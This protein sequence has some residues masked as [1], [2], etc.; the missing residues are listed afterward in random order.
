[1]AVHNRKTLRSRPHLPWRNCRRFTE[2]KGTE[3]VL[4]SPSAPGLAYFIMIYISRRW[5]AGHWSAAILL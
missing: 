1:M 5:A 3:N 4:Y 2:S